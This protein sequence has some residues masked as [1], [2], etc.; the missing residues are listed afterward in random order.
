MLYKLF[1]CLLKD[2]MKT[3]ED[4]G[5]NINGRNMLQ[6]RFADHLILVAVSAAELQIMLLLARLHEVSF[7]VVLMM[8]ISKTKVMTNHPAHKP[9][10]DVNNHHR[11]IR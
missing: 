5:I 8:N 6:L 1:T 4:K 10:I 11:D 2:I 9:N 7:S 3:L